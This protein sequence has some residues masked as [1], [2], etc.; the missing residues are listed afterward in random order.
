MNIFCLH[1]SQRGGPSVTGFPRTLLL[2]R[3][4]KNHSLQALPPLPVG[5][6]S[7]W[8]CKVKSFS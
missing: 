4:S 8:D 1:A 6:L 3:N 2:T 7:I 5:A